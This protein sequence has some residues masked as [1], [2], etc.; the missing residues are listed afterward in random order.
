MKAAR[1][2]GAA[3]LAALLERACT[4][5]AGSGDP[6]PHISAPE[7]DQYDD[8][9]VLPDDEGTE[10]EDSCNSE[11]LEGQGSGT[12]ATVPCCGA[13]SSNSQDAVNVAPNVL[14]QLVSRD[15]VRQGHKG[16]EHQQSS[17]YCLQFYLTHTI[18]MS[19]PGRTT[20]STF[21]IDTTVVEA[22]NSLGLIF[23]GA[24]HKWVWFRLAGT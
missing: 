14:P 24:R 18:V 19:R 3:A 15:D 8:D 9:E 1:A 12:G 11:N 6:G 4:T 5:T 2:A 10:H 13:A 20:Y 21:Y 7:L 22:P 23:D 17:T 16:V